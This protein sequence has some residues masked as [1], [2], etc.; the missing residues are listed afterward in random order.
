MLDF[1][2]RSTEP[3]RMDYEILSRQQ[4]QTALDDISR[5]NTWLGGN[6]ITISALA[7]LYKQWKPNRPLR[8]MDVGCGDGTLLRLISDRLNGMNIPVE[9]IGIDINPQNI[10]L[11][12]EKTQTN[13]LSFREQDIYKIQENDLDVDVVICTLTLHHF[14]NEDLK[15][16]LQQMLKI[17]KKAIIINDLHRSKLAYYL[18]KGISK[19]MIRSDVARHD[20]LVSVQRGFVREELENLSELLP[21]SS[22]ELDWK[23]AFRYLWILHK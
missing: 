19:V 6:G 15:T 5:V 16:L 23:W 2:L 10:E 1:T 22:Y 12:R 20:G 8:I 7:R 3:E 18:F 21:V 14:P 13:T 11:A 4:L 17:T 9:G